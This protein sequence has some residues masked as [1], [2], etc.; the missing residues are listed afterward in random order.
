MTINYTN[1]TVTTGNAVPLSRKPSCGTQDQPY[2]DLIK[3][4]NS[5]TATAN[6]SAFKLNF[7][8]KNNQSL[9]IISR[10]MSAA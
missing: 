6:E 4:S 5:L 7:Y 2:I 8:D 9:F 1:L 10:N 3:K